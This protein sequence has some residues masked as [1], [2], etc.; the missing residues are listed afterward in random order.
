MENIAKFSSFQEYQHLINATPIFK[1]KDS[2]SFDDCVEQMDKVASLTNKNPYKLA[3]T[4]SQGSFS[5]MISSFLSSIGWDKIKE[6]L[7]YNFSSVA[8]KQHVAI[9]VN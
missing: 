4:K 9:N 5:R 8:T 3:L 1:A 2:Q 6:W 7:C